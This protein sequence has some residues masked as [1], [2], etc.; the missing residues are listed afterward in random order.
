VGVLNRLVNWHRAWEDE[1]LAVLADPSLA[2]ETQS[3]YRRR[4]A[5]K[6]A[7]MSA[8]ERRQLREFSVAYRGHKRLPGTWQAGAAF[9]SGRHSRA[10]ARSSQVQS[11]GVAGAEQPV[12]PIAG[13]WLFQRVGS[14]TAACHVL[15]CAPFSSP[16]ALRR[17]GL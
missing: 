10:F 1:I 16:P 2:G 7:K 5:E 3:G 17:W 9:L 13:F 14:I 12:G 15:A 6:L 8:I 4:T 11:G